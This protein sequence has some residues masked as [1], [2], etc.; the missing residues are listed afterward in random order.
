MPKPAALEDVPP[1]RTWTGLDANGA[2]QY[3]DFTGGLIAGPRHMAVRRS[4][5]LEDPEPESAQG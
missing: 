5:P 1:V 3:V 4:V 2:D